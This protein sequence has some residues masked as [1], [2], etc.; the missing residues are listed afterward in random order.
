MSI[1]QKII[2]KPVNLFGTALLAETGR[3]TATATPTGTGSSAGLKLAV[4]SAF[5]LAVA[6]LAGSAFLYQSLN[7]ERRE[8]QAL[9]GAQDQMREKSMG[10]EKSSQDYKNQ[11]NELQAKLNA[12]ETERTQFRK[13]ISE[14]RKQMVLL[15]EKLKEAEELKQKALER[16]DQSES[17]S[18]TLP[19]FGP[20]LAPSLVSNTPAPTSTASPKSSS[21]R[22]ASAP[23][24]AP[25]PAAERK[26]Q[27][28]TV[29]RKFNF[30]VVSLG[31]KDGLQMGQYVEA[32]RNG[33]PTAHVQ[34]EKLYENFAAAT[35][36]QE[37]KAAPIKEGD[38][39]RK[40]A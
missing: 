23:A 22:P 15:Q 17:E 36:V 9:E 33:K 2:S 4:F 14:N 6:S 38:L 34:V 10:L 18:E 13:A 25:A 40:T 20:A 29:N 12:D 37:S 35:I 30:V 24:L 39:I 7:S 27:V 11:M 5:F 16:Q 28:L 31:M 21:A 1:I 8:R 19:E 26:P 3:T 32:V